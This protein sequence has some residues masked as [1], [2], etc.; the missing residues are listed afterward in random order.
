MENSVIVATLSILAAS[1]VVVV[2]ATFTGLGEASVAR[3]AMQSIAQQPD[4]SGKISSTLFISLSMIESSA[5]YCLL[6]AMI[7][8]FSNP[9]WNFFTKH[10]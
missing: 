9:F 6:I 3:Q 7:L 8:I 4:E 10:L 1:I 5:I 2:G